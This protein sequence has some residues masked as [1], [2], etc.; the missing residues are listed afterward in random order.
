MAILQINN[1]GKTNELFVFPK[2][3]FRIINKRPATTL[4]RLAQLCSSALLGEIDRDE[5]PG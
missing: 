2:D 4:G 1:A 3:R 5:K